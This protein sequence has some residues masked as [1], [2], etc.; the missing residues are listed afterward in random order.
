MVE[1]VVGSG[2]GC[3]PSTSPVR[4]C[5]LP[6]TAELQVDVTYQR[7]DV[8]AASAA[9]TGTTALAGV[10]AKKGG[11]GRTLWLVGLANYF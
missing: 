4:C 6:V 1:Q 10:A 3:A 2:Q 8:V 5:S 9:P 7:Q 11:E